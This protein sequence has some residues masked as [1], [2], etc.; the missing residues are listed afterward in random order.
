MI[1]RTFTR[2]QVILLEL[3]PTAALTVWMELGLRATLY[4]QLGHRS[5]IA[6]SLPN[7][8][9]AVLAALTFGLVKASD[10]DTGPSKPAIMSVLALIGYEA[11]QLVI[12]GR[13][14]DWFDLLATLI[15]GII[16][17]VLLHLAQR[18]G[19]TGE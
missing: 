2:Q 6:G 18:V 7:C 11:A 17:F 16:S 15:G 3:V 5:A 1:K 10:P 19:N 4:R 8:I 14:F 12:P 9:V 13:T